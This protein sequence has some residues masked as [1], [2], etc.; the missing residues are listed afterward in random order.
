MLQLHAKSN[1]H[2]T[3]WWILKIFEGGL[4][5]MLI[6]FFSELR[7]GMKCPVKMSRICN[8]INHG[9]LT[10]NGGHV[11]AMFYTP[12][13][14]EIFIRIPWTEPM[15]GQLLYFNGV[16]SLLFPMYDC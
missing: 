16:I 13:Q 5:L 2:E 8:V 6:Y 12:Q 15:S 14:S 4:W 7:S 10:G 3:A 11:G 9:I 1:N